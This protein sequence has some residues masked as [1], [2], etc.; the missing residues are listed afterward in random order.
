M[1]PLQGPPLPRT[2]TVRVGRGRLAAHRLRPD[3]NLSYSWLLATL[4]TWG[5][6][7]SWY[8]LGVS[9]GELTTWVMQIGLSLFAVPFLLS[10]VSNTRSKLRST[11]PVIEL[12]RHPIVPGEAVEVVVLHPQPASVQSMV[13]QIVARRQRLRVSGP[14]GSGGSADDVEVLQEH[15]LFELSA[16]DLG[17][18]SPFVHRTSLE[19]PVDAPC[20]A[21]SGFHDTTWMI[22]LR[23]VSDDEEHELEF[24]LQVRSAQ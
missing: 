19:L 11:H 12:S 17:V 8:F 20:S 14:L 4:F 5:A 18:D 3:H 10:A 16:S 15:P 7:A 9:H 22:E 13:G 1:S 6:G 24:P 23:C 21:S 2:Q